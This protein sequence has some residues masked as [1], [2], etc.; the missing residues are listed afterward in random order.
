MELE[1]ESL[2]AI[3]HEKGRVKHKYHRRNVVW[4]IANRQSRPF[5]FTAM[6][7]IDRIDAIYGSQTSVTEIINQLKKHKKAGK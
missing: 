7:T 6:T 3:F 5:G 2:L 1:A 4:L